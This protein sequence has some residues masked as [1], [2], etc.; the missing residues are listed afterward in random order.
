MSHPCI[1]QDLSIP[2]PSCTTCQQQ[3]CQTGNLW[4]VLYKLQNMA[5]CNNYVIYTLPNMDTWDMEC[6][7]CQIWQPLS[8]MTIQT[9][10]A[11]VASILH[12]NNFS[13]NGICHFWHLWWTLFAKNGNICWPQNFQNRIL[14]IPGFRHGIATMH[15]LF[16]A[17][18][19][20]LYFS[21][22]LSEIE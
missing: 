22:L 14:N 8:H 20:G 16:D 3:S 5:T 13:I 4:Y 10:I 18:P 7:C 21:I 1:L 15:F 6:T 11:K 17:L 19:P 12:S 9:F 2:V